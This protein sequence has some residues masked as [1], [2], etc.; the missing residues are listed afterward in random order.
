MRSPRSMP[1]SSG[2]TRL[3]NEQISAPALRTA[4]NRGRLEAVRGAD[5]EWR[6]SR[7]WVEEYLAGRYRRAWCSASSSTPPH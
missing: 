2:S 3:A 1:S 5:G 7:N 6:S 4:A